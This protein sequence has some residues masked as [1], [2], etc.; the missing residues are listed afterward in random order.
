MK[1][2]E[3]YEKNNNP[4]TEIFMQFIKNM[5]VLL[6]LLC[7][8]PAAYT[9]VVTYPEPAGLEASTHYQWL[10]TLLFFHPP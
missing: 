6:F 10:L 4:S 5:I 7:I 3:N 2:K 1:I 8:V 9:N